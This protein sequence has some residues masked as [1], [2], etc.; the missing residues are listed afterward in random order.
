MCVALGSPIDSGGLFSG[1]SI[2]K[3]MCVVLGGVNSLED[4]ISI[5]QLLLDQGAIFHSEG[6][7]YILI[8]VTGP[9]K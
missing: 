6:S 1:A 8:I 7:R 4:A 5:G 9:G 2:V 3:W